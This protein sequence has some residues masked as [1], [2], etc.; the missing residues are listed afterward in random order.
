MPW[1]ALVD[2]VMGRL[3]L[4]LEIG[5]IC[6]AFGALAGALFIERLRPAWKRGL[7]IGG[8][9]VMAGICGTALLVYF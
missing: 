9:L 5:A 7:V 4:L 1:Y 8:G 6:G 2:F 3:E